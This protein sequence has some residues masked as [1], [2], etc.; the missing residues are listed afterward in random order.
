MTL[1][2][3]TPRITLAALLLASAALTGCASVNLA[4]AKEDA[5]R[6]TFAA[7]AADKA[8]IYIYRNETFGAAIKMP[9]VLDGQLI[10]ETASKTYFYKEV[11]PGKHTVESL[12]EGKENKLE[13]ET[14][15]GTLT[16]IWQEV[17]MGM[18]AAASKLHLVGA[19]EGQKGVSESQLATPR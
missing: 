9:V 14:K 15:G 7:P 17:K 6:K 12:T 5:Q 1:T 11:T 18:W 3:V 4:D 13:V 16:Y 2:A 8:G 19:E 10:G